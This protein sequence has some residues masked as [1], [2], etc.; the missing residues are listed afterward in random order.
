[1]TASY[2]DLQKIERA[3]AAE[4]LAPAQGIAS[5]TSIDDLQEE[6]VAEIAELFDL[7]DLV[8]EYQIQNQLLGAGA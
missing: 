8:I 3:F 7:S 4:L 5:L 6:D 2:T 1:M